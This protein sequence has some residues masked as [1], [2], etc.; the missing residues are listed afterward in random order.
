MEK[1][2]K[3]RIAEAVDKKMQAAIDAEASRIVSAWW[4]EQG[5]ERPKSK[6]APKSHLI[7][8]APRKPAES[9]GGD[10]T[11]RAW[12]VCAKELARG[13]LPRLELTKHLQDHFGAPSPN[14][15]SWTISTLIKKE[16][17]QVVPPSEILRL[18]APPGEV[19]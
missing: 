18:V 9:P 1:S 19:V 13:P 6:R 7:A 15:Y 4:K 8:L 10:I 14:D 16:F 5:T 2:I 3:A 17:L 11:L 12:A